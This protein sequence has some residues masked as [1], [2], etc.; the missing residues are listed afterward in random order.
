MSG[1]SIQSQDSGFDAEG[2]EMVKADLMALAQQVNATSTLL[3]F[4][5]AD[6]LL[7]PVSGRARVFACSNTTTVSTGIAYHTIKILRS[8][9]SDGTMSAGVITSNAEITAYTEF[10]LGEVNC[11]RGTMLELSVVATGAPAPTLT[12]ANFTIRVDVSPRS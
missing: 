5:G 6:R 10:T 11:S 12:T 9:L 1:V 8:G 4:S 3:R 2:H 7:L